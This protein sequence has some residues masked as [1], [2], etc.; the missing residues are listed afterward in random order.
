VK[1]DNQTTNN[2]VRI[3]TAAIPLVF[4]TGIVIAIIV[5]R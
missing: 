1:L 2:I 3:I 4:V 5:G